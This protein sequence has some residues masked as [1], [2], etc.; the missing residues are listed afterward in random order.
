MT[1][2]AARPGLLPI[3]LGLGALI[4]GTVAGF[5]P[6]L[7]DAIVSPPALIRAGLVGCAA[8]AGLALLRAA[9]LRFEASRGDVP[10]MARGVRLIF[11]AV[12]TF[13]AG[14]GWIVGHPLPI[15]VAF[16]IA[17]VDVVETSFL[18]LVASQRSG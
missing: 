13:S 10:G 8:V 3:G 14:A 9:L 17:G 2:T 16:V 11:L 7:L 12:A 1:E 6:A 4:V 5:Q 15:I 18:L